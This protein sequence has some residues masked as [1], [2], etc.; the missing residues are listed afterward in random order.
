MVTFDENNHLTDVGL[1]GSFGHGPGFNISSDI[2]VGGVEGN[3]THVAGTTDNTNGA[4]D[5]ISITNINSGGVNGNGWTVGAGP[6]LPLGFS[7][8]TSHTCTLSFKNI[9]C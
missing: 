7:R 8:T 9:G 2:F 6:G 1:F 4:V 3:G 5:I